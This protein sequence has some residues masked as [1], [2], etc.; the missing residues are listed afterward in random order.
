ML[1]D[2]RQCEFP[3]VFVLCI[4]VFHNSPPAPTTP[5]PFSTPHPYA[6]ATRYSVLGCSSSS[7][8]FHCVTLLLLLLH[9]IPSQNAFDS[10][11]Q[12]CLM[13]IPIAPQRTTIHITPFPFPLPFPFSF[14]VHLYNFLFVLSLS[15][16]ILIIFSQFFL[17]IC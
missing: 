9:S 16:C 7:S 13:L 6:A 15:N 14:P 5:P 12:G 1:N 11:F 4:S 10:C 2:S 17:N 8:A 3:L